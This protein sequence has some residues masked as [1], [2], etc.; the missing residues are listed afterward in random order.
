MHQENWEADS[1][2]VCPPEGKTHFFLL[3]CVTDMLK[4]IYSPRSQ[5]FKNTCCVKMFLKR[6]ELH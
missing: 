5:C 6:D 2:E 1:R 3:K 4:G